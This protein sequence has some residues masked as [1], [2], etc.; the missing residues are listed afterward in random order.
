MGEGFWHE[1]DSWGKQIEWKD[2][3]DDN[4]RE[5]GLCEGK[6]KRNL[7]Y[8]RGCCHVPGQ[9]L[10]PHVHR[11]IRV[12]ELV[13]R[14]GFRSTPSLP[15]TCHSTQAHR[16]MRVKNAATACVWA[17]SLSC[18]LQREILHVCNRTWDTPAP[19]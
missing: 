17:I 15:N 3:D 13:Y 18:V 6:G 19:C 4:E 9:L 1:G 16:T 8:G 10:P 7:D 14:D 11:C 2:E 12:H 5:V